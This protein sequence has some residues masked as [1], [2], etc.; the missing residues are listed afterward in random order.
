MLRASAAC[1]GAGIPTAS[2]TCEGFIN[3][4]K[5]TSVGLGYPG[6]PLAL[7]PGHPG[8]QSKE[9]LRRNTL[10]VTLPKVISNLTDA[11]GQAA[12]SDE[13][14]PRDVVFKGIDWMLPYYRDVGVL[15]ALGM[16]PYEI[17][18]GL[19]YGVGLFKPTVRWSA[20]DLCHHCEL[21]AIQ[22]TCYG[23]VIL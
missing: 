1:E 11:S 22:I 17:L 12:M 8:V 15:I 14:G 7:V 20:Q 16:S 13:P 18:L 9:D 19:F 21:R 3:Q 5:A 6:I 2:L 10:E 4:A 23:S